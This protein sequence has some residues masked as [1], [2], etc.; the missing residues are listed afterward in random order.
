MRRQTS[1][2][3]RRLILGVLWLFRPISGILFLFFRLVPEKAAYCLAWPIGCLIRIGKKSLVLCRIRLLL[4]EDTPTNFSQR[5]FWRSHLIHLGRNVI[6]PFYFYHLPDDKLVA[7]VN[8]TGQEHLGRA[9]DQGR[10]GILFLNH[11]GNPGAIVAG[12]GLRGYDLTIA[13]NAM[14]VTIGSH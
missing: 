2:V 5:E 9:L 12:L 11:L 6:E 7:R 10:G 13:G 1:N 4:G 14:V 8:I 3:V